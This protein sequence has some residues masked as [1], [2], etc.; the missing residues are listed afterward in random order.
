[1]CNCTNFTFNFQD[2]I[3]AVFDK[4]A[5]G[6]KV[7]G[8]VAHLLISPAFLPAISWTGRGK[9][10]ERKIALRKYD[11]L[12]EFIIQIVK[13]ADSRL[14]SDE[15]LEGI[16]YNILKRAP[17]QY[18]KR[19]DQEKNQH[20]SPS[21]STDPA[22]KT[23]EQQEC[24]TSSH[25]PISVGTQQNSKDNDSCT[26][27]SM[28]NSQRQSLM[29]NEAMMKSITPLESYPIESI[30]NQNRG[31]LK[32]VQTYPH[33]YPHQFNYWGNMQSYQGYQ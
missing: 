33:L 20:E 10:K 16:K 17:N 12:V 4:H 15:I 31:A 23:L 6:I 13:K 19:T 11:H 25:N 7:L 22:Q 29:H 21:T 27:N 8:K 1:M 30:I 32:Q 3:F 24:E 28:I 2:K 26:E 14:S 5:N 18:R 9:E